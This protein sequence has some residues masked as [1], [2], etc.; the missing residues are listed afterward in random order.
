[1]GLVRGSADLLHQHT[2]L[3]SAKRYSECQRTAAR[4]SGELERIAAGGAG[5]RLLGFGQSMRFAVILLLLAFLFTLR[6]PRGRILQLGLVYIGMIFLVYFSIGLGILRAVR[7][8][9]DPHFVARAAISGHL[10]RAGN[11]ATAKAWA[12]WERMDLSRELVKE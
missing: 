3:E 4:L 9:S 12:R 8:S 1:M 11:R 10:D 6:Q 5:Y 7:L 2:F